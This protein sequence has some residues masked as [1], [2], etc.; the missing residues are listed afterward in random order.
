MKR[1]LKG[2]YVIWLRDIKRFFR[3]RTRIIGAIGQPALYLFV[4]G[5]GISTALQPM[6]GS[7][8]YIEFLF[9]GIIGMTILFT[10]TFSALSIIWDREF[11]FLKEVMVAPI[12]RT[13]I[14]LGKALGGTT[15]SMIQGTIMLIFTP[16]LGIRITFI[17]L[18]LLWMMMF[19]TSFAMTSFG[20]LLSSKMKSFQGFQM[21]S[22]FLL[23]PMFFLSGSFFPLKN[24]PT[25]M[26]WLVKINPLSYGVD[27]IRYALLGAK[28]LQAF[29]FYL[30]IL[31]MIGVA[32]V[33]LTGAIISFNITE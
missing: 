5:T 33:M 16:F 24:L 15:Q 3:D 1:N 29:P 20:I 17:S 30:D 13:A 31:V 22:N 23:M 27:G 2:I 14:A 9:P 7:G 11:G 32:A 18:S 26:N 6:A 19:L 28:E 21:I 10:S 4:L 8:G 25:W 12:S